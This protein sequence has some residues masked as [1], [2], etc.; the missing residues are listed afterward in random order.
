MMDGLLNPVGVAF[1]A[2]SFVRQIAD[3]REKRRINEAAKR[4]ENPIKVQ[5][6]KRWRGGIAVEVY[7]D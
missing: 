7:N 5:G 3:D 4:N 1:G 2:Y 6:P